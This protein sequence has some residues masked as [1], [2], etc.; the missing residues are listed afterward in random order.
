MKLA[1]VIGDIGSHSGEPIIS[2]S[3]RTFIAG[4]GAAHICSDVATHP[5]E[6]VVHGGVTLVA[7]GNSNKTI[8]YGSEGCSE[9]AQGSCGDTF[10]AITTT[11]TFIS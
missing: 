7:S 3:E 4:K 2:G 5:L 1:L 8:I 6:T 11:R 9:G 10:S